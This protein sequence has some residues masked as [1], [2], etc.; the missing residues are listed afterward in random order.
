M[1]SQKRMDRRTALKLLGLGFLGATA[2]VSGVQLYTHSKTAERNYDFQSVEKGPTIFDQVAADNGFIF[3]HIIGGN[4]PNH[5][6]RAKEMKKTIEG[7]ATK[8]PITYAL[9]T[10]LCWANDNGKLLFYGFHPSVSQYFNPL[11]I[12]EIVQKE[13]AGEILLVE[14]ML[15][16]SDGMAICFD[17]KSGPG[18]R[19]KALEELLE[20]SKGRQA[21][22]ETYDTKI[23]QEINGIDPQAASSIKIIHY[24]GDNKALLFP[25][26]NRYWPVVDLTR[27]PTDSVVNF[28]A[29][30]VD[31][32]LTKLE[33]DVARMGKHLFFGPVLGDKNALRLS[34]QHGRGAFIREDQFT[35]M[36]EVL[37]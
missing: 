16:D 23:L 21:W 4:S 31:S 28:F 24:Q 5:L 17:I 10:D 15:A 11:S 33:R 37:S 1:V 32:D 30:E 20:M 27:I 19:T 26:V 2:T 8:R 7:I 13:R 22:F 14:D 12:R 35:D 9:E 36:M 34:Y 29:P 25:Y 3:A 18:D 6:S